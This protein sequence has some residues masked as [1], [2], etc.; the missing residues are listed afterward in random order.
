MLSTAEAKFLSNS[1]TAVMN[2]QKLILSCNSNTAPYRCIFV[3]AQWVALLSKSTYQ[4]KRFGYF[5]HENALCHPCCTKINVE[6]FHDG[7]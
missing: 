4:Q 6:L 1:A 7:N 2:L 3:V 5:N